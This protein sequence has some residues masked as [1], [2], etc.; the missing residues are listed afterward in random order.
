MMKYDERMEDYQIAVNLSTL[1]HTHTPMQYPN[2]KHPARPSAHM[3]TSKK[4]KK[5]SDRTV[6]MLSIVF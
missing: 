5:K 2:G 3:Q 6:I 1:K 4:K